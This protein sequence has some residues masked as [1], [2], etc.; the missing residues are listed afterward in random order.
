MGGAGDNLPDLLKS[1]FRRFPHAGYGGTFFKWASAST[2]SPY[3]SWGNGAAMRVSPVGF[4]F[5]S[6]DETL[7]H[8]RRSAEVTHDHPEGIKGAQAVAGV[9]FLARTGKTKDEIREFVDREIGY[10][11]SQSWTRFDD[12]FLR[13]LLPGLRPQAITAFLESSTGKMQFERPFLLVGTRIRS[14]ASLADCGGFLQ[15]STT[16]SGWKSRIA[17]PEMRVI[18]NKYLLSFP[19]D[20]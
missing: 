11:L 12:V 6:L 10:D 14:L 1:W 20:G 9:I 5:G 19:S 2:R 7:I 3:N 18:L 17:S 15:R 8:A 16:I 13:C 4:A